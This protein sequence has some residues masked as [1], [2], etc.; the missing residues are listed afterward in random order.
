MKR[1]TPAAR[2]FSARPTEPRWLISMVRPGSFSPM[3]SLESS[4]RCTTASKPER[5]STVTSRRSLETTLGWVLRS[6]KS[7]PRR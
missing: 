6:S 7:Q 4:E 5:S 3:G 2:A 1:L